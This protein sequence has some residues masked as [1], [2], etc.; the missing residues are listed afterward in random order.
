MERWP[1]DVN[2]P[3][4]VRLVFVFTILV[5]VPRLAAPRTARPEFG[6]W[7]QAYA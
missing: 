7:L 6:W 4:I 3:A 5:H 1:V 2:Q